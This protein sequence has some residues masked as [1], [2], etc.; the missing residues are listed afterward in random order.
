VD[1]ARRHAPLLFILVLA[2]IAGL[3]G[4]GSVGLFETSEARY[5]EVAREMVATGDY[6]SPQVNYVYH[7]TKP[8]LTYW[9]TALGYHLFGPT[10]LG[11]RFFLVL[12]A[13]AVLFL[14]SRAYRAVRPGGGEALA[15]AFL[16][17]SLLFFAFARVLTTDM[18]VTLFTTAGFLLYAL[19]E[20]GSLS[21]RAFAPLFG[22]VAGLAFLTKGPVPL[23]VW[24]C[25]LVP[26][27]LWKDRGQSLKPLAHPA[28]WGLLLLVAVPWFVAVGLKH[29]GL[30]EYLAFRESS[31]A[32]YSSTRFHPGPFYYYLP[33]LL[34]GL[35]PWWVLLASRWRETLR[36]EVRLWLLWAVAPVVVWSLFAAKMPAY[37]LPAL[38]AW[39]LL[40]ARVVD[41]EHPPGRAAFGLAGL[42]AALVPA[43]ALAGVWTGKI[44]DLPPLSATA[45]FLLGLSALLGL[46]AAATGFAGR[47]R[48]A[49][50]GAMGALLA[51]QMAVPALCLDLGGRLSPRPG[52]GAYLSAQR[53]PGEAVLEYR[54]TLFSVPF[55][56]RDRVAGYQTS[57]VR[58]KF[59]AEVPE[60]LM[61]T[62]EELAPFLARNPSLWVVTTDESAKTLDAEI[63][64]L[65]FVLR[66][67]DNSLWA[68][69]AVASRLSL[70]AGGGS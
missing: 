60:H 13:V 11:A 62:P 25:V 15:A 3:A 47:R 63:P 12:A 56:L 53:R 22:V 70:P 44:R 49:L 18:F 14:T 4:A 46:G 66:E 64:G 34:A 31:E 8:P 2:G 57:F 17:F 58:K 69:P 29:P 23:L 37:I 67:G 26:Y 16:A 52:L 28:C 27:A 36:P 68:S 50:A 41:S 35:L 40:T 61:S 21:R 9:I 48:W 1:V 65:V 24:A 45:F 19:R 51:L 10:P 54:A 43:A 55:Y 33:V 20:S 6:L 38:P 7:F 32:A 30:L 39:A 42:L 5:A 59:V